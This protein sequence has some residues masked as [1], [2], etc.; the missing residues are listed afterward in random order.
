MECSR[1]RN[2]ELVDRIW[3]WIAPRVPPGRIK[4][5]GIGAGSRAIWTFRLH[6][7]QDLIPHLLG[8][9]DLFL[10]L[11]HIRMRSCSVI[12]GRQVEF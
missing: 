5:Q 6:V 2:L 9:R 8:F 7:G 12:G 4:G 10:R 3:L 11:P 1:V